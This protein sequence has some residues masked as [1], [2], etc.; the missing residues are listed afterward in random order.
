MY[1]DKDKSRAKFGSLFSTSA[2]II[3]GQNYDIY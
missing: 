3:V 1:K 2:H